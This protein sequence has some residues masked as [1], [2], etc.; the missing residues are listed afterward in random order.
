MG[1]HGFFGEIEYDCKFS[2]T[3]FPTKIPKINQ[4]HLFLELLISKMYFSW[5]IQ[6]RKSRNLWD[7]K[8]HVIFAKKS[9]I[10]IWTFQRPYFSKETT[11]PFCFYMSLISVFWPSF[12]YIICL[13][14]GTTHFRQIRRNTLIPNQK[15]QGFHCSHFLN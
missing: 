4:N 14:P 9:G 3:V 8:P 2:R 12:W 1:S 13:Y 7:F 5:E 6:F 11:C 15:S 10:P